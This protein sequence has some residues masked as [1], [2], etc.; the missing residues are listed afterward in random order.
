MRTGYR[1]RAVA[2]VESTPG[3]WTVPSFVDSFFDV[4]VAWWW[5]WLLLLVAGAAIAW[6]NER[7]LRGPAWKHRRYGA[8]RSDTTPRKIPLSKTRRW[9]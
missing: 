8:P 9:H 2:G 5:L 4:L 6:V 1:T 7:Q 3:W